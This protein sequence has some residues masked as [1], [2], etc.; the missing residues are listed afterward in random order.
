M[1]RSMATGQDFANFICSKDLNNR[2]L[3]YLMRSM[4]P[5]WKQLSS[6]ST[7]QTI[8]M[9]TFE[10]L[11]IVLPPRNAQDEIATAMDALTGALES[12][13]SALD[14]QR[15]LRAALVDQLLSGRTRVP[16]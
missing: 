2:Y 4:Q 16:A 6:G 9:P 14:H 12:G 7:H 15:R 3:L 1:G 10:S 11:Q 13:L 5:V 8:Y